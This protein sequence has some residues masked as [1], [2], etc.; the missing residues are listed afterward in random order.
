LAF[1]FNEYKLDNVEAYTNS[2][3]TRIDNDRFRTK[4]LMIGLGVS[5][6]IN[7]SKK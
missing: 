5:Y 6:L 2:K 7:Q 1:I 4:S 3:G